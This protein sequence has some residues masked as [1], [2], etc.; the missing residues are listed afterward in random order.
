MEIE[1][2]EPEDKIRQMM[3][4]G[5]RSCFTLGSLTVAVPVETHLKLNGRPLALEKVST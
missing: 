5:E 3:H 2:D 1:S 4:M